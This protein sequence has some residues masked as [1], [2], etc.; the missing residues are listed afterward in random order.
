[1]SML[2]GTW[3]ALASTGGPASVSVVLQAGG[4]SFSLRVPEGR[5]LLTVEHV[6][7]LRAGSK[8]PPF[9]RGAGMIASIMPVRGD[10]H[11]IAYV[12]ADARPGD[13]T[14]LLENNIQATIAEYRTT[15]PD[16]EPVR[17][18]SFTTGDRR[19]VP[20]LLAHFARKYEAVA[21]IGERSAT[22]RVGCWTNDDPGGDALALEILRAL[23]ASY[24][25]ET[26]NG[27]GGK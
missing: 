4:H 21:F 24:V 2:I 17:W 15:T 7:Q 9:E 11:G 10:L 13:S 25:P 16:L 27:P 23:V 26:D 12:S 22:I 1:L 14:K 8:L 3:L 20:V 5:K 18:D 6:Q 19:S